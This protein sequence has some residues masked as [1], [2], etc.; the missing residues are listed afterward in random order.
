MADFQFFV[1]HTDSEEKKKQR[2]NWIKDLK[3]GKNPFAFVAVRLCTKKSVSLL[4][5]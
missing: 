5:S 4:L 3:K 2:Q 1:Q